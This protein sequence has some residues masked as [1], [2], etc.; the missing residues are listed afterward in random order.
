LPRTRLL[1]IAVAVLIVV[2]IVSVLYLVKYHSN[3]NREKEQYFPPR[4]WKLALTIDE[5]EYDLTITVTGEE[6]F[7]DVS[8]YVVKLLFEPENPYETRM[9]NEMTSWLD[10][11]TFNIVK[12]EGTGRAQGYDF[13][14]TETHYYTF[15]EGD[16][17]MTV[18]KRI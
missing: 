12:L 14:Y 16:P 6:T 4:W 9:S 11:S 7:H 8:C 1:K 18:G 17:S 3:P 10:K 5:S 2:L 13:R 15:R